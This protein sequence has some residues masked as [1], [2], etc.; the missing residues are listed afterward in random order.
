MKKT[1]IQ[2][3]FN[4]SNEIDR[5]RMSYKENGR[6]NIFEMINRERINAMIDFLFEKAYAPVA[7]L[8]IE[9]ALSSAPLPHRH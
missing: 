7:E 1:F 8:N 9:S 2:K 3:V 6:I 5:I 4:V